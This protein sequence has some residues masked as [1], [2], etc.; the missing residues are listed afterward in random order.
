VTP[1]HELHLAAD[2]PEALEVPAREQA[3]FSQLVREARALFGAHHYRTYHFL[4]SLSDGLGFFGLEHHESSDNRMVER[5]LLEEERRLRLADLLPHEFVHS[6]NGKYRRPADLASAPYEA[7]MRTDLLWV[8]E[9]LTQYLGWV[10]SARCGLLD[11]TQARAYLAHKAAEQD[12]RPGRSWR[13]LLDT[14][15]SAPILL[16]GPQAWQSWRRGADFYDEGLLT[17]LDVDGLI[18]ERTGEARS[19]DDFC[20]L[21]FGG[22][23]RGPEVRPYTFEDVVA[24]LDQIAPGDWRGY[25]LRRITETAKRTPLEGI[26]RAGWALSYAESISDYERTVDRSREWTEARWSLG[27]LVD[28]DGSMV[29]V[30]EGSPASRAGIGP[31]MKLIA[32]DGRKWTSEALDAALRRA[33]AES[34]RIDLLIENGGF[35]R[36]HR[37]TY[38]GGPRFP[39]LER[40]GARRDRLSEILAAKAP[41]PER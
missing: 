12:H 13:P 7:P 18:R 27:F 37:V 8:Y 33:R 40:E 16:G 29:D 25:L 34:G 24:A 14:A 20:R 21:F 35:F 1:A 9:G 15:V 23:S 6:W 39:R 3:C 17:W 38:A 26:R 36:Q 41:R 2:S 30:V 4:L 10:L 28:K 11:S 32:V 22:E 31:G 5:G 19:L